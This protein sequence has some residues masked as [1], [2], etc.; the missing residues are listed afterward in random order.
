MATAPGERRRGDDP[1]IT[2]SFEVFREPLS[3]VRR[4]AGTID[5]GSERDRAAF[6]EAL[7]SA[8]VVQSDRRIFEDREPPMVVTMTAPR[9]ALGWAVPAINYYIVKG[10][11]STE[12]LSHEFISRFTR[13]Y[14]RAVD[15][16]SE[17]LGPPRNVPRRVSQGRPVTTGTDEAAVAADQHCGCGRHRGLAWS[18]RCQRR[19]R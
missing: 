12:H 1:L 17:G 15:A 11:D 3:Y 7:A 6:V 10:P 9:S 2:V 5:Y 8:H 18:P 19:R 14:F 13:A 4:I 16:A